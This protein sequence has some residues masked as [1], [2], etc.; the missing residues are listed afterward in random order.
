VKTAV[1]DTHALV[2]YLSDPKRLGKKARRHLAAVDRGAA[3]VLIP[4][5]VLVELALVREA[6]RRVIG[7]VEVEAAI[8]ANANVEILP[9]DLAQSKEFVLLGSCPDP[10]DRMIIAA[11]RVATAPLLTVD[12]RITASGLAQVVWE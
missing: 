2:W 1:I 4:A 7:P 12:E 11:A 8:A 10:F 6:G 5:I 3:R 9:L